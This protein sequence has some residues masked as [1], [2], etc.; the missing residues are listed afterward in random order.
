[1][2]LTLTHQV[3]T[4]LQSQGLI[5]ASTSWSDFGAACEAAAELHTVVKA[6]FLDRKITLRQRASLGGAGGRKANA[7]RKAARWQKRW[8][9]FSREHCTD[10]SVGETVHVLRCWTDERKVRLDAELELADGASIVHGVQSFDVSAGDGQKLELRAAA[11]ADAAL[12]VRQL[13]MTTRGQTV[14]RRASMMASAAAVARAPTTAEGVLDVEWLRR[15]LGNTDE[16]DERV[17][18]FALDDSGLSEDLWGLRD[19]GDVTTPVPTARLSVVLN[20]G[21]SALAVL[22]RASTAA[23]QA[24]LAREAAVLS[25]IELRAAA[26]TAKVGLPALYYSYG[27]VETLMLEHAGAALTDGD[28]AAAALPGSDGDGAALAAATALG[29]LHAACQ[30]HPAIEPLR[31]AT[32]ALGDAGVTAAGFGAGVVEAFGAAWTSLLGA[33][34]DAGLSVLKKVAEPSAAATLLTSADAGA[35]TLCHGAF[36]ASCAVSSGGSSSAVAAATAARK[37]SDGTV[38]S[39]DASVVLTHFEQ[40]FRGGFLAAAADLNTLLVLGFDAESRRRLEA[41][42]IMAYATAF[43]SAAGGGI[44]AA[45]LRFFYAQATQLLALR[46]LARNP[47]PDAASAPA[48][49]RVL[50]ALVDHAAFE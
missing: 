17:D 44:S 24:A 46:L 9:E 15:A 31:S 6:G 4:A 47:A 36:S 49:D 37:G 13:S 1:M 25:S 10:G 27:A 29:R 26:T 5:A 45:E 18:T 28:A 40:S 39:G 20:T 8:F 12:W 11:A 34:A 35:Q 50:Q 48:V 43:A 41:G 16:D 32:E 33:T 23:E 21:A 30:S 3:F 42:A 14:K 2:S 19:S 7:F 22:K 38:P